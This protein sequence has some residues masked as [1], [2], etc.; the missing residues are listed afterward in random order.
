VDLFAEGPTSKW[1]LPVPAPIAGAPAGLRR[2]AF[3]LDGAPPG[4]RYERALLTLTA[5][6]PAEAIE[7]TT[8]LD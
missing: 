1:A 6:T 7:V 3:E 8:R 2:F 5:V 4:E